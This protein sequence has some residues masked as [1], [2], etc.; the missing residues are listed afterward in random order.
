MPLL[1]YLQRKPQSK[2]GGSEICAFKI[3]I[4][5]AKSC[6]TGVGPF[7]TAVSNVGE[8]LFPYGLSNKI[9]PTQTIRYFQLVSDSP[10]VD[11]ICISLM[12]LGLFSPRLRG[13][14]GF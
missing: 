8:C 1:V 11:L 5:I 4:D 14:C 9:Y 3:L 12:K 7:Y 6:F 10:R 13:I 2:I